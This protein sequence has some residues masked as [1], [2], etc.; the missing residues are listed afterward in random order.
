MLL[1]LSSF[2]H[3][4]LCVTQWTVAHQAPLSM[5]FSLWVAMPSCGGSSLYLLHLL[6]W[7]AGSLPPVQPEKLR[8]VETV[9][10]LVS[11]LSDL[12][13]SLVPLRV[14]LRL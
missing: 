12:A 2:S 1:L 9:L 5:R 13:G 4:R 8:E 10:D 6:R 11:L 7:Q 3:V 14:H